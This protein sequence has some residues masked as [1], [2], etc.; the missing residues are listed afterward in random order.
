[1]GRLNV[2]ELLPHPA[3]GPARFHRAR[4]VGL[5]VVRHVVSWKVKT[6]FRSYRRGKNAVNRLE[7]RSCACRCKKSS[8]NEQTRAAERYRCYWFLALRACRKK[9][10]SRSSPSLDLQVN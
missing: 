2:K 5:E 8:G 4:I 7:Q 3:L 6:E 1:M 9:R 10:E